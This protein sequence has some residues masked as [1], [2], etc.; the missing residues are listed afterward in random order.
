MPYNKKILEFS[1]HR[2]EN[3]KSV[4]M[5]TNATLH[6]IFL[7]IVTFSMHFKQALTY[8][9]FESHLSETN[10]EKNHKLCQTVARSHS[11]IQKK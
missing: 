10:H 9:M 2:S 4:S 3:L 1:T 7:V 11:R 5:K 8:R 6:S